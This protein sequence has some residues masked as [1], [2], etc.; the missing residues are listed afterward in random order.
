MTSVVTA[1][2]CFALSGV[3]DA[4]YKKRLMRSLVTLCESSNTQDQSKE[5][6]AS[7]DQLIHR[8][9]VLIFTCCPTDKV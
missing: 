2:E 5:Q 4:N 9:F 6:D 1:G 7:E 8:D 3:A